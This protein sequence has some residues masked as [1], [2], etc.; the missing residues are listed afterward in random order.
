MLTEMYRT[1]S[2][3]VRLLAKIRNEVDL[4][5]KPMRKHRIAFI[6]LLNGLCHLLSVSDNYFN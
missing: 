3:N 6:M 4:D 5:E 2:Y 1:Y